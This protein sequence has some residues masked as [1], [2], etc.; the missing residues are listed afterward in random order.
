MDLYLFA[1]FGITD[2]IFLDELSGKCVFK[3]KVIGMA[4]IWSTLWKWLY[5]T[6]VHL[7][8]EI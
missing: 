6:F 8:E 5:I 3:V 2:G 1:Y 7:K 4:Q